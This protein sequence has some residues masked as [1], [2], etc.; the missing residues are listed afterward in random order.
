M[1]SVSL[2]H[3]QARVRAPF[4][5]SAPHALL[6]PLRGGQMLVVREESSRDIPARERLLDAAFGPARFLK[7]S[8]ALRAGRLPARGLALSGIHDGE[9]VATVRLWS[10]HAGGVPAL[11]L[12]PLAVAESRRSLGVGAAMME[13]AIARASALGHK[14]IILVGDE[15]YYR[16]FGFSAALTARLDMPGP[17]D[18]ARFLALALQP[19]ALDDAAGMIVAAGER[20]G[21]R[22]RSADRRRSA[23]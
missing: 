22:G 15:P 10:I 18:R 7:T 2:A 16:R 23:A 11:L 5:S 17:V 9:L 13:A 6:Q 1:T 12:G 20:A 19:G 14:A 8:E 21:A 4:S 3:P